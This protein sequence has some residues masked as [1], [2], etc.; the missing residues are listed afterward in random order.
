MALTVIYDA[1]VLYPQTLRS[2]LM[3]LA[4]S[5]LFQARWTHEIHDEWIGNLLEKRPDLTREKLMEVRRLMDK[6]IPNALIM[7]Y[8]EIIDTL[9]LP[10][11]NDRHVLA[12][13]IHG[14]A[15]LIVTNNTR[16][17]PPR[18]LSPYEIEAI[19]PDTFVSHLIK[20]N[21][22]QVI[23]ALQQQRTALKNPAMSADEYLDTLQRQGLHSTVEMLLIH[24]GHL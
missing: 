8:E 11:Q 2:A 3:Y 12:A 18:M 23:K 21:L 22:D 14:N 17:F 6:A 1:R 7:G 5:D 4:L 24:K 10:D 16:D 19:S 13:A 15:T 20:T 9:E